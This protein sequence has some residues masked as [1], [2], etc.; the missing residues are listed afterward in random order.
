MFPKWFISAQRYKSTPKRHSSNFTNYTPT[1]YRLYEHLMSRYNKQLIPKRNLKKPV[2]VRLSIELYQV[3]EVVS[4][5]GSLAS[6]PSNSLLNNSAY[7]FLCSSFDVSKL[8][9]MKDGCMIRERMKYV[10]F[11]HGMRFSIVST[12]ENVEKPSIVNSEM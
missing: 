8:H 3:I 7:H 4:F 1:H 6:F 9:I 2:S 5:I 11:T 12:L 10:C